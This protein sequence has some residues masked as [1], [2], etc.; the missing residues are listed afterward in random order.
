MEHPRWKRSLA[1]WAT[2]GRILAVPFIV[3]LLL[4]PGAWAGWLAAA[5]FIAA[6]ITDYYDGY[7]A[8]KYNAVSS[9]GK[10]LDPMAD[11]LLVSSVLIMLIPTTK[12]SPLMVVILLGRDTVVSGLRSF[13]AAEGT[14]I[15]ARP[16]GKWK[17]A[18]QMVAIPALLINDLFGLPVG[19]LGYW[20]M[21]ITVG[22]SLISG[23]EYLMGYFKSQQPEK[24]PKEFRP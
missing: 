8:R 17:T 24:P 11:K 22:L 3:I 2:M 21:W 13:A 7:W 10:L 23:G 19:V 4:F 20:L 14:I 12:I 16:T 1:L 6:S 18:L 15:S 5:L 9:L